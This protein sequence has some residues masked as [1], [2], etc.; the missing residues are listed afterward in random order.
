MRMLLSERVS[1][2]MG[3][4]CH[5]RGTTG[6]DSLAGHFSGS[7]VAGRWAASR[8]A[9]GARLFLVS[10]F[11]SIRSGASRRRES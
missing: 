2:G 8:G 9:F 11:H 1:L 10:V 5:R 6:R 4:R 3:W 7:P